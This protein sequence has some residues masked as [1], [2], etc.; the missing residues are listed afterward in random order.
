MCSSQF[1][2]CFKIW[3]ILCSQCKLYSSHLLLVNKLHIHLSL[4]ICNLEIQ[5]KPLLLAKSVRT[6]NFWLRQFKVL[7]VGAT[8]GPSVRAAFGPDLW[9]ICWAQYF[10]PAQNCWSYQW[11]KNSTT[12]GPIVSPT[13]NFYNCLG[14]HLY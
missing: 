14:A 13:P 4:G 7:G 2:M 9:P 12:K 10:L 6:N 8:I 1:T 11:A 5:Q 3:S